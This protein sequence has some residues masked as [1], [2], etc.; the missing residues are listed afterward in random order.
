MATTA[1]VAVLNGLPRERGGGYC[2]PRALRVSHAGIYFPFG[3]PPL[4]LEAPV[5]V[6]L[7]LG[8]I[9]DSIPSQC[10]HGEQL[11]FRLMDELFD[12]EDR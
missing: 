4:S 2:R 1:C 9:G 8:C 11:Y 7:H 5:E 3:Q 12:E 6:W 10:W